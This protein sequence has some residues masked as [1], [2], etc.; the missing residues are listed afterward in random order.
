LILLI[1]LLG[2][3]CQQDREPPVEK[4]IDVVEEISEGQREIRDARKDA[5]LDP[6]L[7]TDPAEAAGARFRVQMEKAEAEHD[8]AREL[9]D[10]MEQE[11]ERT[12]CF[13][14]ARAQYETEV[15]AAERQ[16]RESLAQVRAANPKQGGTTDDASS[17]AA[18]AGQP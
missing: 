1:P 6:T 8:V 3:A 13:E 10:A 2:V 11:Q 17:E 14:K 4:A 16:R 5:A 9:C 15:E 18:G 12:T 7:D